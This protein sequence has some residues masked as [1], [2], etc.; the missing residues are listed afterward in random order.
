MV[1]W[2][3][4]WPS[5]HDAEVLQIH[6]NRLGMSRLRLHAWHT[7]A[8]ALTEE[9]EG[10]RQF[11]REQHALVTFELGAISDLELS[12]FS[13]QNVLASLDIERDGNVFRVR[14]DPLYGI[15]GRIDAGE[16][17]VFIQPGDPSGD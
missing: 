1:S 7:S 6:L 2:F 14:L 5:F 17:A 15:G 9:H 16:C 10:K 4:Y 12:D 3:G 13:S 8:I 11:V